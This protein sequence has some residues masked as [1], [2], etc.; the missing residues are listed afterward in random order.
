MRKHGSKLSYTRYTWDYKAEICLLEFY[1]NHA[2][3]IP[4]LEKY[5]SFLDSFQFI[6]K[7]LIYVAIEQ[8]LTS[9]YTK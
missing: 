7:N 2:S 3:F 8:E 6:L 1:T 9:I 4:N 5:S